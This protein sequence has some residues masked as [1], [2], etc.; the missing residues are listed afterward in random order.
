[1]PD[2]PIRIGSAATQD[3]VIT[4]ASYHIDP[5]TWIKASTLTFFCPN[6]FNVPTLQN[7]YFKRGQS[8]Q[9]GNV[10]DATSK[11]DEVFVD[12]LEGGSAQFRVI[13]KRLDPDN[14]GRASATVD[15]DS[16][17]NYK[18]ILSDQMVQ[19]IF[20][21]DNSGYPPI[22]GFPEPIV[23]VR[24]SNLTRPPISGGTLASI[25]AQP[26]SARALNFPDYNP[27]D[28]PIHFPITPGTVVTYFDGT[29]F[30][31]YNATQNV[32]I[33]FTMRFK[34]NP[35]GWQLQRLKADEVSNYAFYDVE[36]E[37]RGSYFFGGVTF[38]GITN[39]G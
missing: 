31:T 32:T 10:I 2:G 36:E 20:A 11:V 3:L 5:A 30:Q 17:I 21:A 19:L 7:Q 23:R 12:Y 9:F 28:V 13:Y 22:Y 33:N 34:A 24:Y 35:L 37:W 18:S 4:G 38:D 15:V 26:G 8:A 1:M 16:V 25:Y 14:T 6:Q 39:I 29:T 27:I